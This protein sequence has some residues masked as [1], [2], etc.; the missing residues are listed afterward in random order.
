MKTVRGKGK[1]PAGGAAE[2]VPSAKEANGSE[3]FADNGRDGKVID[4]LK[5]GETGYPFELD[6]GQ[7]RWRLQALCYEGN[8]RAHL[9]PW[10]HSAEGNLRPCKGKRGEIGLVVPR[11][12]LRDLAE[13][14]LDL[15]ADLPG[16]AR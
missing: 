2:G 14:L 6:Y 16:R 12:R 10:F 4:G 15:D 8:W 1:P 11:H 13:A 3:S 5:P 7:R 9:W